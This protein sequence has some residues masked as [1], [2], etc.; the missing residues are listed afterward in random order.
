MALTN[1][2]LQAIA[3]LLDTKLDI[4]L[5]PIEQRLDNIES[6]VLAL[7]NDVADVKETVHKNY[8]LTEEFY[9]SQ[10]EHNTEIADSLAIV[11]GELD[12]HNRQ[13]ARNTAELKRVK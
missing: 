1:E 3:A 8:T 6:K 4:K 2:D 9:V 11:T 12:M 13:I 10:K 5:K 7:Q